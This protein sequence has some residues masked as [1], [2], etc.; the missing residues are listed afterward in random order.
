MSPQ[1]PA[2]STFLFFLGDFG[3][4]RIINVLNRVMIL[5]L[6]MTK[7]AERVDVK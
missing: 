5:V 6:E 2:K 4:I 1:A 3:V 7:K